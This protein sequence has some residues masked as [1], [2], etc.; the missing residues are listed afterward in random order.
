M[1]KANMPT[2]RTTGRLPR[3]HKRR[4]PSPPPALRRPVRPSHLPCALETAQV[5]LGH[6]ACDVTQVYAARDAGKAAAV[7]LKIG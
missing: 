7:A 3:Y 4:A 2:N 1:N 5:L 6:A